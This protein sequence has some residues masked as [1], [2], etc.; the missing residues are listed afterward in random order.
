MER[1][2]WRRLSHTNLDLWVIINYT[3]Y[4][5]QIHTLCFI[6]STIGRHLGIGTTLS[7]YESGG[8]VK[9]QPTMS[10][11]KAV[12][13]AKR[14]KS[15]IVPGETFS[16]KQ[17]PLPKAEDLKDGE[18]IFQT[19][20]L[21]LDPAMRGWLNGKPPPGDVNWWTRFSIYTL[22]SYFY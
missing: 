21:S 22:L 10:T 2:I 18:V 14:P 20:Y 1:T 12:H 7:A 4:Q 6:N 9:C 3:R 11:Y 13:L 17:H 16:I 15:T 19:L 8:V 5:N